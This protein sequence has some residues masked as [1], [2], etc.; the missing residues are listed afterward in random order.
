[1]INFQE[2]DPYQVLQHYMQFCGSGKTFPESLFYGQKAV[3]KHAFGLNAAR[4]Y[5]VFFKYFP[6][7]GNYFPGLVRLGMICLILPS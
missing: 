3:E 7:T 6:G 4:V 1:M 5:Y 2:V